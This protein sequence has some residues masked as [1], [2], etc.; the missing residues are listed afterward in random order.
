MTDCRYVS[1]PLASGTMLPKLPI[2][3]IN[4]DFATPYKK[5]VG[6]LLHLANTTRPDIAFATGYLSRYMECARKPH[7]EAAKRVLRFLAGTIQSRICY[8]RNILAGLHG[9]SDSDFASDVITR[10][11]VSG[12]VFKMAG[13]AI[14]W[15]SKKQDFTAQST[16]EAEFVS[17]SFAVREAVW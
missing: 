13:G 5:L 16:L 8:M 14:S 17:M 4:G 12:F 7:W 15:R 11:S 10:R 2:S 9:Y 3:E 6:S 1:A